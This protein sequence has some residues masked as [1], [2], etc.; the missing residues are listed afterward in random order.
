M[1]DYLHGTDVL[2]A[3][4]LPSSTPAVGDGPFVTVHFKNPAALVAAK[5]GE[6]GAT[7]FK[8]VPNTILSQVYSQ[9]RDKIAAGMKAEG[10]DADVQVVTSQPSGGPFARDFLVGSV[11]GAG[12]VGVVFGLWKLVS[13]LFIRKG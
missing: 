6:I 2:G 11:V 13:H 12:S 7:M 4:F 9:T 8:L 3:A 1:E 10:A 5:G